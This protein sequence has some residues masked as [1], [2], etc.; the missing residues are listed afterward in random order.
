[1]WARSIRSSVCRGCCQLV[2]VTPS[3]IVPSRPLC[4]PSQVLFCVLA[5]LLVVALVVVCVCHHMGYRKH[6]AAS[7]LSPMGGG[8]AVKPAADEACRSL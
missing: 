2:S 8:A 3:I 5:M 7:G 6:K 4:H 1:M